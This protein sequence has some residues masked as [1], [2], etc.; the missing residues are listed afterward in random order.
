PRRAATA[1][2]RS[3][4]AAALRL[5]YRVQLLLPVR[6]TEAV[7]TGHRSHGHGCGPG[8]LEVAFRTYAPRVRTAWI[9]DPRHHHTIPAATRRIAPGTAAYWTALARSKYLVSNTGFDRRMVKRP[10][11]VVVQTQLGTPLKKM[12]LDLLEHPAAARSTDFDALLADVDKWDYVLSANR[13][14]TL[15]W[16]RVYPSSY[17]TLEYGQP[18]NDL[19]LTASSDDRERIRAG[20]GIPPDT[21][22]ILYAPTHRDYRV[23][24]RL[25]LDLERVARLLGPRFMI[26]AR[27]HPAYGAPLTRPG[28][29][30]RLVDVSDHPDVTALCVASDA[31]VTDYSSLMFDYA[32]LDRP[33]VIHADDWD[34]YE[35]ARG[36]YFDL[37]T[38]P[39][40]AVAR[41]EDELID[42]FAT[43]H[44]RGSRS[45]QLRSAF[46]A[47][48]CP[49]DDGRAAER[50][51]RHVVLGERPGGEDRNTDGGS[52]WVPRQ[53]SGAAGAARV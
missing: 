10:G 26:L 53:Q 29:D 19:L 9:A 22:A 5:H 11:Q 25:A 40:G 49:Y 51:V 21:T 8:A 18:S 36:T 39:P 14:S 12:G 4:A 31:L 7:F 52:P 13:H 15:V 42:I 46:R 30:G 43:G 28:A 33:I 34:A 45:G 6:Q 47:R 38:F 37:R 2:R 16:E 20:L 44:W 41:S 27:S 23:S 1:A 3:V 24:Q 32:C 48:F 35:A 50:V 17:A